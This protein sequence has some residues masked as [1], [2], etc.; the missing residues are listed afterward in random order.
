M[1]KND[2][3]R[4]LIMTGKYLCYGFM[5]QLFT[6]TILFA[7]DGEA[8]RLS[9]KDGNIHV[10]PVKERKEQEIIEI[11]QVIQVTGTVTS[12]SDGL[13]IPGVN[14]LIKGTGTGT[15]TDVNGNYSI[16][17]P[18]EDDILVFSS[19]GYTTQEIALNGRAVIDVIMEEDMQGLDE[20]VVI[21]Y[22]TLDKKEVTSAISHISG[23][24]LSIV[25]SNDPLMGLQGKVSGLTIQNTAAA[26]PNSS[27]SIQ[28]RGVTTR[29][30]A[31]GPLIVID[32]VPGGNLLSVNENDIASIDILKDGAASAIYGTRASNG[33]I[34]ITTKS[35]A[36]GP[37]RLAYNGFTSVDMPTMTLKV[38]SPEEF[39]SV[40]R[41]ADFN[42]NTNWLDEISNRYAFTQ[43]HTLSLTG[44]GNNTT[45]RATVDYQNSS[46]LDI[47]SAR[48]QYGARLSVNHTSENGLYDIILN[49][50]P[51]FAVGIQ[52][53]DNSQANV[54]T[55]ALSLNPTIPVMDPDNPNSY[56]ML[57]GWGEYNP[58]EQ[59]NL[60]ENGMEQ[61]YLD[62]NATF[63]LN[64]LPT[65]YTQVQIAQVS[66]DAFNYFFE[67]SIMST[68]VTAGTNGSASRSYTKED[69][70]SL[71]WLANYGFDLRRHSFNLLGVYS[72]QYFVNSGLNAGNSDFSSDALTYN[73]LNNGTFNMEAGRNGFGTYKGDNRLISFRGRLNYSYDD[74]YLF[75][76]SLTRDGSSRFGQ[77]NKW[78]YFPGIS[79]G[80]RIGAEPFMAGIDWITDLKIRTDYGESGNQDAI[81][82]YQSLARYSGYGQYMYNG[83]YMQVWG[84]ANNVN[85]NLRW[86]R[87]K[88]WNIGLDF[89]LFRNRLNGT[90]NYYSRN[91]VDLLG[92]YNAPLPPNI[93]T[94]TIANVGSMSSNGIEIELFGNVINKQDFTYN[95]SLNG[96]T[97]NAVFV[98]F[99]NELYQG[100]TFVDQM[101]MPAPGSPGPAQRLQEG[102]R[103]G[104]FYFWKHAGVDADGNFLIYNEAGE[105]VSASL[106]NEDDKQFVG[107]GQ[108]EFTAGMT[109]IFTYKNWDASAFFRGVFGWEIFNAHEFY[110][111]LQ[112]AAPN[113]NVL[114]SAYERN[115]AI[116]GLPLLTDFFLEKGDFIKLD[117]VS[118]GYTLKAESKYIESVRLYGS[119]RN[120]LT[121]T[122]FSGVDPD[123]YPINGQNPGILNNNGSG[124]KAY[125]PSTTQIL[126]GAQVNF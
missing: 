123:L 2:L 104:M 53:S 118:L 114:A 100:Q 62:W 5:I 90:A 52:G 31:T 40:N 84:P 95:I 9:V 22:G 56:Y 81:S 88:N 8:H 21:G 93:A 111:G 34:L 105:V 25:G 101:Y 17:A 85:P 61:K 126:I 11:S 4:P 51:R 58:V 45:Y 70:Y 37:G 98:S 80:W 48:E 72:Y 75:S 36:A 35:G 12:F 113:T 122:D 42:A 29:S 86:E 28:L 49:V 30:G 14:I 26:D 13:G 79:V 20:V 97:Q 91:A 10:K 54:F 83:N 87:L 23:D 65:L 112:S 55:Q 43:K 73:D 107:N 92:S 64:F 50:A 115:A 69:Q 106:A 109:H 82:N 68:Q 33:V 117:V 3:L 18:N 39:R 63:K 102:E 74:K 103:L 116:T 96:A 76:A 120:L 57:G 78:G 32:G 66:S 71:E 119:T 108:P 47:R 6:F 99:S 1:K 38:M 19:I 121:F 44:G 124:T 89:S 7:T 41:G 125:Y 77:N 15:V 110:F 67:P 60:Q 46:G 59:L 24:E 94:T 27:A 16:D